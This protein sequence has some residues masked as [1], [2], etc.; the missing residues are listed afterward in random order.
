MKVSNEKELGIALE[1]NQ[2]SIEIE[3]DLSKKVIKI[4]VTKLLDTFQI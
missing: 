4:K 3:G 1:Q 2:D